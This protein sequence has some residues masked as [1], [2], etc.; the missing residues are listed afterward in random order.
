M[1]LLPSVLKKDVIRALK[2]AKRYLELSYSGES[3]TLTGTALM[4]SDITATTAVWDIHR[5][6][7]DEKRA[8]A[9]TIEESIADDIAKIKRLREEASDIDK[10]DNAILFI[11]KILDECN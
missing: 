3:Y 1:R 4:F 7:S 8:E 6:P 5:K 11:R 9:R 10:K 2:Y